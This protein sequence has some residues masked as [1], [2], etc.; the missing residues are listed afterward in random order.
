MKSSVLIIS[1]IYLIVT[2][3]SESVSVAGDPTIQVEF[4]RDIRPILSD[5]CFPCHGP[6]KNKRQ[7]DL[8]LDTEI[9]LV[10]SKDMPG[11]VVAGKPADSNVIARIT[12]NVLEEHMPP[13]EFGKEV[14]PEELALISQW[15]EQGAKWQ[16]HWSF[17]PI[18]EITPPQVG[19][20]LSGSNPIDRFIT[21]RLEEKKISS[22]PSADPR[23][24]VRRLYFDLTGL[25]P[26]PEDVITFV[27]DSSPSA[28]SDLVERLLTSQHHGE[29]M[30]VWWLDLVRYAD[31]VGY[32][33]D[34]EVSVS[35]YRDYVIRA[36]NENKPFDQFTV[37]QLAGDLLPNPTLEQKI[38]SGYNRLGM[39]SAEGGVQD[40]EYLAKYIAER[41]RNLGGTWLGLTLGCCECHDHKFDPISTREFYQFEAFFA[42]IEERGLYSGDQWGT[43]IQVPTEAQSK[44]LADL[45]QKIVLTQAKLDASTPELNAAELEWESNVG[46]WLALKPTSA[47][48]QGAATL[49]IQPDGAILASGTN[50]DS[51]TYEIIFDKLPEGTT[52]LRLEVLP[53]DSLPSK[54][55]GRAGNGNFVLTEIELNSVDTTNPKDSQAI[56]ISKAIASHEQISYIEGNPY[57]KWAIDAAID[58]DEKGAK[59]GWAILDEQGKSNF[60]IFQIAPETPLKADRQLRITIK[61]NLDNPKHTLGHFR[62]FASKASEPLKRVTVVPTEIE[63]LIAKPANQRS[64]EESKKIASHFRSVTP[65]LE[66]QRNTL[67]DLQA[68]REQLNRSIPTTLVTVARM[69]RPVKVLARGNWMDESGEEVQPGIPAV[70]GG[71]SSDK[72]LTRLDLANWIV[73]KENPLTARVTVNRLW[74]IFFGAGLTRKL[75]DL[76]AQGDWPSHP[77]LLDWLAT[78]FVRSGWD[79]RHM[80][81][82]IVTSETYKQSSKPAHE[83][84]EIDPFNR[85]LSYQGRWRL[86]AE[87]VRDSALATSGLLTEQIGGSSVRPYQPRGYWAYLNFPQREWQDGIGDQLYRRGIYTHWQRQYL[88]PSLLAFDAPSREECTADRPRSNTPLQALAMLNDPTYVEAARVFA[89]H[90]ILQ[91]GMSDDQRLNWVVNQALQRSPLDAEM[92]ILL[93][94]LDQHRQQYSQDTAAVDQ[95]ISVGTYP[96]KPEINRIELA[97]WTSVARAILNLHE[98]ITRN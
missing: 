31:S 61:Q 10:G 68:Q 43:N 65:L 59:W 36:F 50:P 86:E 48:S 21:S 63:N 39:M 32:H 85:L 53:H 41:V 42:D 92:K 67:K 27:R 76:G 89:Y 2:L 26:S 12:T 62:F 96:I 37:E 88:H 58:R 22:A 87:F 79:I 60:A 35:P 93:S 64:D 30:A 81:R 20:N 40:K 7:A 28:Y 23:T 82:M 47:N 14:T 13:K 91:E 25:P 78:E 70:L 34:Q 69:P 72:R 56:S 80:I 71:S 11:A 57:K 3:T 6:D 46:Q 33:G 84:V 74:K 54:G 24:L 52:A 19:K 77:E 83:A 45:D 51:D 98:T 75:D 94:L 90:A 5:K 16:G 4:N 49:T 73:A 15:I 17:E 66:D 95:L 8:R 97:A 9:G 38:A 55:P 1:A 18:R 29:R 44:Q